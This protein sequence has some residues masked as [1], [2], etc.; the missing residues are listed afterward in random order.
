MKKLFNK[1]GFTLMEMMIVIAIIVILVAVSIPT[2]SGALDKANTATDA[3]NLRAAKAAVVAYE[4][5]GNDADGKVY[6]IETGALEAK[7]GSG[8]PAASGKCSAHSACWIEVD[9]DDVVWTDG[10][11][12]V[13]PCN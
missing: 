12:N 3:A 2:F 7:P 5:D 10:T 8:N 6:N 1:K 9:G 13:D 11:N 4:L